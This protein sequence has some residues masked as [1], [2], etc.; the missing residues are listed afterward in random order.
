M[1]DK[2]CITLKYNNRDIK[3]ELPDTY[4]EFINLLED[5]L[6]L[7]PQLVSSSN[8]YYQDIDG[9]KCEIHRDNYN[10]SFNDCNGIFEMVLNFD[11]KGYNGDKT[12]FDNKKIIGNELKNLE[13]TIAKKFSK[14]LVKK[15]K[16][17]DS[18][19][20]KEISSIKE[21]FQKTLNTIIQKTENKYNELS[22]YYN[23]KI[24]TIFQEYNEMIIEKI[25]KGISGSDLN[26]LAEQFINDNK[27]YNP[28]IDN[29]NEEKFTFSKVINK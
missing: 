8:I 25:N 24:K 7:T 22:D 11:N 26:K 1:E 20:K 23:E 18:E 17:K 3:L 13:N 6:Y 14:I 19:H 2:I 29:N 27:I 16:D 21:E 10:E 15:L 28:D 4:D 5:K 12:I 9:D